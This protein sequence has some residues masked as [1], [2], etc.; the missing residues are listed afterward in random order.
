MAYQRDDLPVEER[1][2]QNFWLNS[3]FVSHHFNRHANYNE[4][5]W[6]MGA[7]YQFNEIISVAVGTY[8]NSIHRTTSYG[9]IVW[10]PW[11]WEQFGFGFFAGA[12]DGYPGIH[13]GK[14]FPL[15]LPVITFQTR[16]VGVN[17]IWIPSLKDKVDGCVALQLKL[18]F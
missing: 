10:Q 2:V 8:K 3:G 6:G 5:N 15:V 18:P 14:F 9:G 7:E 1:S 13:G 17:L 12:A 11:H 4:R 16:Y